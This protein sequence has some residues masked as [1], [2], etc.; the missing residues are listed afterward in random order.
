[1]TCASAIKLADKPEK[2]ITRPT[3]FNFEFN[4]LFRVVMHN[5]LARNIDFSGNIAL[6]LRK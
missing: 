3:L 6:F 2:A 1:M 5:F 4:S